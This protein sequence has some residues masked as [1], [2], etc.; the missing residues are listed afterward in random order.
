MKG[1]AWI[2]FDGKGLL[3]AGL[4][5][6]VATSL[7]ACAGPSNF[8]RGEKAAGRGDWEETVIGMGSGPRNPEPSSSSPA[9][10]NSAMVGML[11]GPISAAGVT[12]VPQTT[13]GSVQAG[14]LEPSGQTARSPSA[15]VSI[16]PSSGPISIGEEVQVQVVVSNAENL[17]AAPFYF[18]YNP[19][20]LT[21]E[22]VSEGNFLN[23][24]GGNTVFLKSVDPTQGRII[25]G[26][27]RLGSAPG[28]SGSGALATITFKA[29]APGQAS[30]TLAN[31]NFKDPK[32]NTLP[33]QVNSGVVE[34][35]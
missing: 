35:R 19:T 32:L 8:E 23:Q 25:V 5:W 1:Q 29:Q 12:P 9:I 16:I 4:G 18:Y 20:A 34:I 28:M 11:P 26:L 6:L 27:S 22:M 7:L 15:I 13:G 30:I 31:V 2:G 10:V 33:V 21:L 24:D 17:F 3:V 14:E